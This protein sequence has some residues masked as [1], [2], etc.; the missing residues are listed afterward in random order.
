MVDSIYVRGVCFEIPVVE[1]GTKELSDS[2]PVINSFFL[3]N[4]K[5]VTEYCAITK[6]D[7]GG[8]EK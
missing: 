8:L 3:F 2:V 5:F 1:E 4:L 6:P 7:N